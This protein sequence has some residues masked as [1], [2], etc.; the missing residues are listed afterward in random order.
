[1][2]NQNIAALLQSREFITVGTCDFKGRPNVAPKFLLKLEK[3]FIFLIDYTIGKTLENLKINPRVSLSIMDLDALMGYQLNGS[4]EIINQGKEYD[5]T[6]NE[7]LEKQTNL[8]AMRIIEGLEKGKTHRIF[9]LAF[10]EQVVI[11]KI[12]IE[13]IVEIAPQGKLTRAKVGK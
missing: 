7:F 1:M 3:N 6:L 10:P 12:K 2:L 13:E 8:S 11:Y 4:A 5:L 9:E